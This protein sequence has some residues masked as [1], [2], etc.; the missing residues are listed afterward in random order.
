M[1]HT[2]PHNHRDSRSDPEQS[3]ETSE[4]RETR[5]LETDPGQEDLLPRIPH[6]RFL[7]D[8]Q[9]ASSGLDQEG[10]HVGEDEEEGD[11]VRA[12][13]TEVSVAGEV[14]DDPAEEDVIAWE[15]ECR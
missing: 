15:C 5:Q 10:R 3:P 14:G 4:E 11:L 2:Q 8:G 13:G 7:G 9:P 6:R 12:D 1:D